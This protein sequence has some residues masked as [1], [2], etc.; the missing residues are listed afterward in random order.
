VKVRGLSYFVQGT[1]TSLILFKVWATVCGQVSP[2]D[3]V[4]I[5]STPVASYARS[6]KMEA[7]N[8]EAESEA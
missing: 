1:T 7:A 4:Q 2:L 5:Q 3:L 8:F 6:Y